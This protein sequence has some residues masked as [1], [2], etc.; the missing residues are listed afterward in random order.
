M[1]TTTGAIELDFRDLGF[2][3]VAEVVDVWA[4]ADAQTKPDASYGVHEDSYRWVIPNNNASDGE[5][6]PLVVAAQAQAEEEE[7]EGEGGGY[8]GTAR[9]VYVRPVAGK[10]TATGCSA[11]GGGVGQCSSA[12][13]PKTNGLFW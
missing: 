8:L 10:Y 7:E 11:W 3:G 6:S 1:C 4:E 5:G 13:Q 12:P 2:S 9:F